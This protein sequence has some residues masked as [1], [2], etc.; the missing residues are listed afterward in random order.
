MG[1][2]EFMSALNRLHV[3]APEGSEFLGTLHS[4]LTAIGGGHGYMMGVDALF[5]DLAQHDGAARTLSEEAFVLIFRRLH[6]LE[7]MAAADRLME[8]A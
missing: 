8:F 1:R 5:R 4:H 7:D 3:E 2:G 6:A